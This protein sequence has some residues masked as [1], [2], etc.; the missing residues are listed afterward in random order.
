MKLKVGKYVWN[1]EKCLL[2]KGILGI[3]IIAGII[4]C[5]QLM[6][7]LYYLLL[8]YTTMA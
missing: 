2:L 8:P 5:Y 7:T 4:G 1:S 3:T 6:W